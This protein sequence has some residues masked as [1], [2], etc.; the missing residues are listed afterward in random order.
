MIGAEPVE[1][2]ITEEEVKDD[3]G[4]ELDGWETGSVSKE[5]Q[6]N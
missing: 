3:C 6:E 5:H 4:F 2:W 1:L